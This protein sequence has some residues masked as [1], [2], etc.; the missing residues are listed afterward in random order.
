MNT[1]Q[2][3]FIVN[4][5]QD[6]NILR[7]LVYV[8]AHRLK[9][10]TRFLVTSAFRKR[11]KT[12]VWQ[13][14]L[15][16]IATETNSLIHDFDNEFQAL[17]VLQTGDGA[18]V[19]ASESNL[20]A[21]KPVHDLF[22]VTPSQY[23]KIT[24]QHGFECVGFLQ[25][26]DQT[27]AH[28]I[29]ITF[30]A[31]I[32]C[33]WCA[34]ERL[35]AVSPSQR[36]K[37]RVTGPTA[38]LPSPTKLNHGDSTVQVKFESSG[39]VCE[40]MHSSRLNTAGDFKSEFLGVFEDFCAEQAL[41]GG[42]VI[43]R[44]HP[45]GQYVIKNDVSLPQN[46]TLE[47]GPIYKVDL[48]KFAYGISAPSSILIDMVLAGIPTAVWHDEGT[49]MDLGNY[50]GLTRIS[51]TSDW[52]S[53]AKNAVDQRDQYLKKQQIFLMKQGLIIER[54]SILNAFSTLLRTSVRYEDHQVMR[55]QNRER[56]LLIVPN[57]GATVQFS[58]IKPLAY[59]VATGRAVVDVIEEVDLNRD[60]KAERSL[61]FEGGAW[62]LD[63]I[64]TITPTVAIFCR[65]T[66][67][68]SKLMLSYFCEN[69]I[70]T[71]CYLDDDLMSVP[72]NIGLEK[73]AKYNEPRRL[74][75]LQHLLNHSNLVYTSN[76][77]LKERIE[78]LC[79]G[80]RVV[81]GDIVSAHYQVKEPRIGRLRKI[82]YM[83][84]GHKEDLELILVPLIAYLK[85]NV[86]V[87]FELFG[88]I[89]IPHELLE[90]ENR[91]S[92]IEKIEDYDEFLARLPTLEWDIGI[93][94]LSK[95][96]FNFLK[97]NVKWIEYSSAGI[98]VIASRGTVYD[99]CCAEGCGVLADT[100]KDWYNALDYLASN[101]A[102]RLDMVVRSQK[103]LRRD[104]SRIRM[105]NQVLSMIQLASDNHRADR[106]VAPTSLATG[107]SQERILL[108]AKSFMPTLEIYF[109]NP[110][111]DLVDEKQIT[112]DL[113]TENHINNIKADVPGANNKFLKSSFSAVENWIIERFN[114]FSPTVLV[115]VRYSG[116]HAQ[117]LV[118]LAKA[119]LIPIIY[120]IDDDLLSVPIEIGLEKS[121][122]HNNPRRLS[123]V[124]SLLET[125]TLVL[126]STKS[127]MNRLQILTPSI[128][129]ATTNRIVCTMKAKATV[130][131]RPARKIGYMGNADHA[132][133]FSTIVDALV[134]VLR[135]HTQITFELF[136][137]L[138]MPDKLKEFGDR[139]QHVPA[140]STYEQFL[141][142]FPHC[143]WDIGLCPLYKNSFNL[144]KT[145]I[146]WFDYTSIG[147]AVVASRGT[148]YDEVCADDC[149]G[150]AESEIEWFDIIDT[151]ITSPSTRH[152]MAENA[153]RKLKYDYPVEHFR[154]DMI[155]VFNHAHQMV[156]DST[157]H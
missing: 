84:I 135:K 28:G 146:K 18:L 14:E 149:G 129:A 10:T 46:V 115:F 74:Q 11:D 56:I 70:P 13:H 94:P 19:A 134:L 92:K 108:V 154:A 30:A 5:L 66:G 45:G 36:H 95:M 15:N 86:D 104:F 132:H 81:A 12:G 156:K 121:A 107:T 4:L 40:N 64:R 41:K 69:G 31:D 144:M 143:E 126:C 141:T 89:P 106:V 3:I 48:R 7:P 65:W 73:W 37:L 26:R 147:A 20:N 79:T 155:R 118:D 35:T 112:I 25:S 97:S 71:I 42:H 137:S 122:Y 123:V 47:N 77:S 98:P 133:D 24:L 21:H 80:R 119:H 68:H 50:E 110:L 116:P 22:R 152:M 105:E 34:P 128:S 8:A 87:I 23:V 100:E 83:G 55:R 17:Q 59:A 125:S 145:P 76:K 90:F 54:T 53:F 75:S 136:G 130:R 85:T 109:T 113:I 52:L 138:P 58:F 16:E 82:G 61:F 91:I 29:N 67:P 60:L 43:L 101:P 44:P 39:L 120:H 27:L 102:V 32:V 38:L 103:K 127:L 99:A 131:A 72:K 96:P 117:L 150:L 114:M 33:G 139:I 157:F 63:R 9:L 88:T 151:L 2:V 6:I 111:N 153:Q 62:L 57:V 1:R 148:V 93:C 49:V 142:M 51:T 124:K 78:K 140:T